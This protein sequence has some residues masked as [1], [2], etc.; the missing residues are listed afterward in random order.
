M[1]TVMALSYQTPKYQ[2]VFSAVSNPCTTQKHVKICPPT[3]HLQRFGRPEIRVV[4]RFIDVD[5]V[6]TAPANDLGWLP[7]MS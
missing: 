7:S 6:L 4:N 2:S 3:L 5:A 1:I